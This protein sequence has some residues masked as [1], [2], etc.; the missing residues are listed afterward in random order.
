MRSLQVHSIHFV[1]TPIFC[2][3]I[4]MVQ[5]DFHIN[6]TKKYGS[7]M[8]MVVTVRWNYQTGRIRM[9]KVHVNK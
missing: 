2:Q 1:D 9:S 5:S 8:K 7:L 4:S 6:N 3:R